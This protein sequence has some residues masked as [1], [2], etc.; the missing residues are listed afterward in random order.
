MEPWPI[1]SVPVSIFY[2]LNLP[3]HFRFFLVKIE[4]SHAS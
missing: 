3:D 1:A 4:I 2:D